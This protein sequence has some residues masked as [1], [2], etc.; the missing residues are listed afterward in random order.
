MYYLGVKNEFSA[1]HF[2]KKYNGKCANLHGH[3][4][5]VEAVF[6]CEELDES[7]MAVDF[8]VLK[9]I[10]KKRMEELDHKFLNVHDFFA[11]KNTT[12]EM[13]AKYIY[14][15]IKNE[16]KDEKFDIFEIKVWESGKSW[17]SYRES[18]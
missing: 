8:T 13:I 12:A 14:D 18:I 5:V 7:Y 11:E 9:K 6:K 1:A 16:I 2:L 15:S 17:V 10:L 4:W 3:N